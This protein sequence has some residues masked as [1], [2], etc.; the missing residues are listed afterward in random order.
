MF[1]LDTK[2]WENVAEGLLSSVSKVGSQDAAGLPSQKKTDDETVVD[3]VAIKSD[4]R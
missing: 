4:E 2:E 1:S 3:F